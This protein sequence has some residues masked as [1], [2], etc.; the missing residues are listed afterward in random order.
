MLTGRMQNALCRASLAAVLSCLMMQ[1]E[2]WAL[3]VERR[4]MELTRTNRSLRTASEKSMKVIG[5]SSTG[6]KHV[7]TGNEYKQSMLYAAI[8]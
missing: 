8:K 3:S 2:A 4:S 6:Q 1:M 5:I 7:V